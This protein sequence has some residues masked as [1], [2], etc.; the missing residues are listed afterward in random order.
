MSAGHLIHR[1]AVPLPLKGKDNCALQL[2]LDLQ[3]RALFATADLIHRKRSPFPYEGK[4]L[5]HRKVGET[6][7]IAV[8]EA[9][10]RCPAGR[11]PS[12][13]GWVGG[14]YPSTPFKARTAASDGHTASTRAARSAGLRFAVIVLSKT[15]D[16]GRDHLIHRKRSPFPEKTEWRVECGEWS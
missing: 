16:V 13:G 4:A 7:T 11:S 9:L 14:V 10:P 6:S 12:P 1:G 3:C 2:R 8:S 15:N 5:T